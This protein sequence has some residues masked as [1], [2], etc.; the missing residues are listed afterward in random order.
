MKQLD[1]KLLEG[2]LHGLAI[3]KDVM[4]VGEFTPNAISDFEDHY[5]NIINLAKAASY[6]DALQILQEAELN[7]WR[8]KV[9]MNWTIED[10]LRLSELQN[11][12]IQGR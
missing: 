9:E 6:K 4:S 10:T 12:N 1:Y 3:C 2:I 7:Y 5:Q 8:A 11:K